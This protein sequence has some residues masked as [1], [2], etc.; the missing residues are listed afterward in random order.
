MTYKYAKLLSLVQ[1]Q[2]WPA[3]FLRVLEN[4]TNLNMHFKFTYCTKHK[5]SK[6]A[7]K[8]DFM[9]NKMLLNKYVNYVPVDYSK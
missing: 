8:S 3:Q 6:V 4:L 5:F 2:K 1:Q 7:K 9:K